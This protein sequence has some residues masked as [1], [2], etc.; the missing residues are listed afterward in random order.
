LDL[1]PEGG[2][3]F[4]D[5]TGP[6]PPSYGAFRDGTTISFTWGGRLT[7]GGTMG[8]SAFASGITESGQH[9][10]LSPVDCGVTTAEGGTYDPND[11]TGSCSINP[12]DPG[13]ITFTVANH[14]GA[15]I[16]NVQ[17]R[18][19][20]RHTDGSAQILNLTGPVPNN[21]SRLPNGLSAVY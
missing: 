12:G 16:T 17:P 18:L 10:Q 11:F 9:V 20:A 2:A 19:V 13:R 3:L 21:T 15:S 7:P 6:N 8:F 4:F 5:P 14:G 1:E